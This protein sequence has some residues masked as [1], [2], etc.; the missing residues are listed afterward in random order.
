MTSAALVRMCGAP[1]VWRLC[2]GDYVH[3]VDQLRQ[4]SPFDA[5]PVA[6][7]PRTRP[8]P[9]VVAQD[10]V[11]RLACPCQNGW[12]HA[13]AGVA[14]AIFQ[15]VLP[16][17]WDDTLSARA[18]VDVAMETTPADNTPVVAPRA[19]E[20]NADPQLWEHV[21]PCTT[22]QASK[23]A[24]IRTALVAKLGKPRATELLSKTRA[25]VAKDIQ[26]QN[27]R[28]LRANGTLLR[29]KATAQ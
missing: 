5:A 24:D 15:A 21:E 27:H 11:Q 18:E 7:A 6:I 12:F 4:L 9:E 1:N 16:D 23:A 8:D 22:R 26:G 28:V 3:F 25:T 19:E 10:A 20:A 17:E 14:F 29:L 13:T 2:V